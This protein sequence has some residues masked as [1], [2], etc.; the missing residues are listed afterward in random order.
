MHKHNNHFH[1]E[2]RINTADY[3]KMP[4][5][6][7][8]MSPRSVLT[9]ISKS[10]SL[11]NIF[12]THFPLWHF[13]LALNIFCLVFDILLFLSY[14]TFS[15]FICSV[16]S[17]PSSRTLNTRGA[18]RHFILKFLHL[19]KRGKFCLEDF[20]FLIS[21]LTFLIFFSTSNLIKK[22]NLWPVSIFSLSSF[23]IHFHNVVFQ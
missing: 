3:F 21:Y 17:S 23:V 22:I 13:F 20:L 6:V 11:A 19:K 1:T 7:F 10:L 9:R 16:A 5:R 4:N 18:S 12:P 14:T 8:S 2:R 15:S